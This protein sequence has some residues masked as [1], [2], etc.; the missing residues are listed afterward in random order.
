MMSDQ[1]GFAYDI[2]P[3]SPAPFDY[4]AAC[5]GS[6]ELL[7]KVERDRREGKTLQDIIQEAEVRRRLEERGK[8]PL[9]DRRP[10][11]ADG[12]DA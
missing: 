2:G 4:R 11:R 5:A 12:D 8:L 7:D 9:D 10:H 6:Q 3:D 1:R